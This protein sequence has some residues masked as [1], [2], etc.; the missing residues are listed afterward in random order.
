[1]PSRSIHLE[2]DGMAPEIELPLRAVATELGSRGIEVGVDGELARPDESVVICAEGNATSFPRAWRV[3]P[4]ITHGLVHLTRGEETI[5]IPWTVP[6]SALRRL[7]PTILARGSGDP[8]QARMM[9]RT[10]EELYRRR[11]G[12]RFA[13]WGSLSDEGGERAFD[14]VHTEPSASDLQRLLCSSSAV[15]DPAVALGDAT[16]LPW[17]AEAVGVAVVV[18]AEHPF[19]AGIRVSEWSPES[20]A[21]ALETALALGDS[22]SARRVEDSAKQL[23]EALGIDA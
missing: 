6:R 9:A 7:P 5:E 2:T 14:E 8:R 12:C 20:F 10:A 18:S 17:M 15:F 16:P 13:V 19:P 21:D 4:E 11:A 3:S 1:M 22:G 23:L